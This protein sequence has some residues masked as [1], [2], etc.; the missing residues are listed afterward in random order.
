[1]CRG[2]DTYIFR[3][4]SLSLSQKYRLKLDSTGNT[5][6]LDGIQWMRDGLPLRLESVGQS[7]LITMKAE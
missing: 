2:E 7:E 5:L 3:P 6:T 1:M 4:R